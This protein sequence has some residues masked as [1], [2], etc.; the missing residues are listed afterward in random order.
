QDHGLAV[1][2]TFFKLPKRRLYTWKSPADQPGHIVRNLI[3]YI[4][5]GERFKN[6]IHCVKTM[7]GADVGSDHNL[8]LAEMRI[9]LKSA[10]V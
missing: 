7:R 9:D 2:N 3:D 6:A 5:V 8:L 1:M 4:T 10:G